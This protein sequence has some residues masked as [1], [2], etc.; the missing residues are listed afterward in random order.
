MKDTSWK[1]KNYDIHKVLCFYVVPIA[2][3]MALTGLLYASESFNTV[4]K[5]FANGG[6]T[7]I[8]PDWP[9]KNLTTPSKNPLDA[10]FEQTIHSVPDSKYVLVKM[11]RNDK[12][13][14]VIRSYFDESLNYNRLVHY[15][16]QQTAEVLDTEKFLEKNAGD[17]IQALN[18]DIHI[19]TIG[20]WPTKIL[21]F[22][23]SFITTSLPGTGFYIWRWKRSY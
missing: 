3:I 13:P 21:W 19:G 14:F 12:A 23:V 1:Q 7:I 2:L 20:G 6:K 10:A 16:D 8:E 22:I 18:Y 11:P 4:V 9:Q 15:Y 17:K 5:W